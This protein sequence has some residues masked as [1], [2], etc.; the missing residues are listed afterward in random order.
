MFLLVLLCSGLNKHAVLV[1]TITAE[2]FKT[3]VDH[4]SAPSV[5]GGRDGGDTRDNPKLAGA[6][7]ALSTV[8]DQDSG[9]ALLPHLQPQTATATKS[10]PAHH[11]QDEE[12]GTG[13]TYEADDVSEHDDFDRG[14]A[15]DHVG[16]GTET[17]HWTVPSDP[18]AARIPSTG[19]GEEKSFLLPQV[20]EATRTIPPHAGG[21]KNAWKEVRDQGST[22]TESGDVRGATFGSKRF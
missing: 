11:S 6:D 12:R 7:D 9:G 21:W 14:H 2:C 18:L 15:S 5:S 19:Q 16:E 22:S 4:R 13:E 20:R 17:D 3:H 10:P 1:F 8:S